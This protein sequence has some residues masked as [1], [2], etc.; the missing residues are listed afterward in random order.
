MG[1]YEYVEGIHWYWWVKYL[2][3]EIPPCLLD[4]IRTTRLSA[5]P[6]SFSKLIYL[7]EVLP[8]NRN[9]DNPV[10][11]LLL[12]E[13]QELPGLGFHTYSRLCRS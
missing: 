4:I 11:Q 13:I 10:L 7:F 5:D 12:I 8:V 6:S 9:Q 3:Q 1:V 2:S